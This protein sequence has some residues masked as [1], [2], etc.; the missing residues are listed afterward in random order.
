MG[1]DSRE[2]WYNRRTGR[3]YISIFK[4][5]D[6]VLGKPYDFFLKGDEKRAVDVTLA[7]RAPVANRKWLV[8]VGVGGPKHKT[9]GYLFR[10]GIKL[11][12]L[13]AKWGS[14]T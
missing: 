13:F 4:T 12:Q 7:P 9:K 8:G 5:R 11:V 14:R 2:C 10:Q 1:E 3:L 6:S